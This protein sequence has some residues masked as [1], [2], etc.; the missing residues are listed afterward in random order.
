MDLL[1]QAARA[2]FDE[3]GFSHDEHYSTTGNRFLHLAEAAYLKERQRR[4]VLR[5]RWIPKGS[6][7]WLYRLFDSNSRLLYVGVTGNPQAR[8]GQHKR[9]FGRDLDHWTFQEYPGMTAVLQ[10]EAQ[11]ITEESPAFNLNHPRVAW[12]G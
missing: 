4:E 10:A 7:P 6:G 1:E 12:L 8:L 9:R 11:A 2:Y 5:P 3:V